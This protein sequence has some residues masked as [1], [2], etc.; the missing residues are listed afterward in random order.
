[1]VS[2]VAARATAICSSVTT[3]GADD[4]AE[5]D[6][7]DAVVVGVEEAVGPST[8]I[9]SDCT[10]ASDR[11]VGSV[12]CGCEDEDVYDCCLGGGGGGKR[13]RRDDGG[14]RLRG[15]GG[16]GGGGV[17]GLGGGGCQAVTVNSSKHADA[18]RSSPRQS[19]MA[20]SWPRRRGGSCAQ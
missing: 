3:T 16:G 6:D 11:V 1:V 18:R 7:D 5:V 13:E 4:D 8:R 17:G 19:E 10:R 12:G 9:L 2:S 14:G 20:C 15:G